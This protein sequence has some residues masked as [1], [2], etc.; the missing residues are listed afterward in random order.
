MMPRLMTIDIDHSSH[1]IVQMIGDK[2]TIQV[3]NN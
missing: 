3:D 2:K 1:Y